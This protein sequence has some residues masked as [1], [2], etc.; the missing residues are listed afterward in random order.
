M[1]TIIQ[2]TLTM[3]GSAIQV[4]KSNTPIRAV[5]FEYDDTYN[6]SIF[7][8]GASVSAS[9]YGFALKAASAS[10]DWIKF[11]GEMPGQ[12]SDFWAFGSASDKLHYIAIEAL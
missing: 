2:G 4:T 10:T 8:G 12:L 5:R 1:A 11:E 7:V 9:T 3:T 6:A